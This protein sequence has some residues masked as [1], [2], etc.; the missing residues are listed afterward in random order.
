MMERYERYESLLLEN[1][2]YS[3]I[4]E[5]FESDYWEYVEECTEEI[6]AKSGIKVGEL[7]A[8]IYSF[9]NFEKAILDGYKLVYLPEL[10]EILFHREIVYPDS[11]YNQFILLV[12]IEEEVE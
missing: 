3:T 10:D 6:E 9:E 4:F 5:G 2:L 8:Y 12:D 1:D 7:Q 11:V